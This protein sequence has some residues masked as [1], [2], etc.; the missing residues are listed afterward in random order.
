MED[1]ALKLI[2]SLCVKVDFLTQAQ[3]EFYQKHFLKLSSASKNILTQTEAADYL[4]LK[5]DYLNQLTHHKKLKFTKKE[6]R[7]AKYFLKCDLD[8]YMSGETESSHSEEDLI[9][10]EILQSWSKEGKI[11]K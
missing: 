5:P 6:G 8:E 4:G 9:E 7:K 2:Q 11:K 3:E 10:K 1:R